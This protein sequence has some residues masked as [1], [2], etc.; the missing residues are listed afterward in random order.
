M[1]N[2]D[3][4]CQWTNF[5]DVLKNLELKNV[6]RRLKRK[7]NNNKPKWFN[8]EIQ[9][10]IKERNKTHKKYKLNPSELNKN[11]YNNSKRHVKRVIRFSKREY[12][13]L[14]ARESKENPKRFFDYVSNKKPLREEIGPIARANCEV[15]NGSL[16]IATKLNYYF[17]SVFIPEDLA[18]EAKE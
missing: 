16:A 17:S 11:A 18:T 13:R 5:R 10:A 8:N 2:S 4:N 3:P 9:E 6:P 14:I 1:E 15:I 7:V 12:E